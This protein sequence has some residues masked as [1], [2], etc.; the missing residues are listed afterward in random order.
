MSATGLLTA[1]LAAS[2]VQTLELSGLTAGVNALSYSPLMRHKPRRAVA[3]AHVLLVYCEPSLEQDPQRLLQLVHTLDRLQASVIGLTVPRESV[4][5]ELLDWARTSG[6]LVCAAPLSDVAL[7][8]PGLSQGDVRLIHAPYGIYT[9]HRG[10]RLAGESRPS[11]LEAVVA[12]RMGMEPA[13]IPCGPYRVDFRGGI[14]SLPHVDASR[15]LRNELTSELVCGR[16]VLLGLRADPLLP[17]VA[18]PTTQGVQRMPLLEFRG[19]ALNSLLT[20]RAIRTLDVRWQLGLNLSY[21]MLCVVV[22]RQVNLPAAALLVVGLTSLASWA[23]WLVL[24]FAHIWIPWAPLLLLPVIT[25]LL[26]LDRRMR[27][28]GNTWRRLAQI[29]FAASPRHRH[30]PP[31]PLSSDPW[32][33]AALLLDQLFELQRGVLLMLR[34]GRLQPVHY[35]RSAAGDVQETRGRLCEA[36]FAEAI[37]QRGPLRVDPARPFFRVRPHEQQFLLPLIHRGQVQGMLALAV[38]EDALRRMTSFADDVRSVADEL[39]EL[40]AHRGRVRQVER[41]ERSWLRWLWTVPE[42]RSSAALCRHLGLVNRRLSQCC[43]ADEES[44]I[45]EALYDLCGLVVSVNGAMFRQ[46]QGDGLASLDLPLVELIDGLTSCGRDVVRA[47]LRRVILDQQMQ[48]IPLPAQ[49]LGKDRVLLLRP[50]ED[51]SPDIRAALVV[52][53]VSHAR[54]PSATVPAASGPAT[55][56]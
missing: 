22:L 39:A 8:L 7:P 38:A 51:R 28:A 21:A 19:H 40:A 20:R 53:T 17:G 12:R 24:H 16:A 34:R 56:G 54:H 29:G 43:A 52:R 45:G 5:E 30:H 11:S 2:L 33:D 49:D 27:L 44:V 32:H 4:A 50:L 3:E 37:E 10:R 31:L 6:R 35:L 23:A 48:V 42:Q 55:A 15:V 47:R 1:L 36:P 9:E 13:A 18:T 14:G 26:V 46:L 25:S 41:R